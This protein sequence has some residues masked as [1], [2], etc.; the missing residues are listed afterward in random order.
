[1]PGLSEKAQRTHDKH[2]WAA[3]EHS[4]TLPDLAHPFSMSLPPLVYDCLAPASNAGG[5]GRN[6]GADLP[7]AVVFAVC[8]HSE[9][10]SP[11]CPS[12]AAICSKGQ[13]PSLKATESP[14]HGE[15]LQTAAEPA[16]SLFTDGPGHLGCVFNSLEAKMY[17]PLNL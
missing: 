6:K 3:Q 2:L 16:N 5:L 15:L 8:K 4:H 10:Q 1:M 14:L 17:I 11:L 9:M 13:R 12:A 7:P